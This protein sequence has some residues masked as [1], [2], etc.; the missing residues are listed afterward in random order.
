MKDHLSLLEHIEK[1]IEQIEDRFGFTCSIF[2]SSIIVNSFIGRY[3][4]ECTMREHGY[5]AEF[6]R[7]CYCYAQALQKYG[8]KNKRSIVEG[9]DL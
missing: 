5:M 2:G 8:L 9:G 3:E 4:Y 1:T 7:F 6:Y